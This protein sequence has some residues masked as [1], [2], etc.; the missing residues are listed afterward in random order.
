MPVITAHEPGA[1]EHQVIEEM[2]RNGFEAA[3]KH[4][5]SGTTEPHAHDYDVCL[6]IL[7]GEF[8]LRE[9]ESS[10]VHRLRPGDRAFVDRGTVH[11]EEHGPV[12]MI[13]G[14]RH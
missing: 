14:R 2:A 3:T 5:A 13:V 10:A 6:Y 12:R 4:Y 8:K 7:E 11:A 9:L 1:P